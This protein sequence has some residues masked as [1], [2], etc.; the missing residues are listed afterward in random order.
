MEGF[1]RGLNRL[2]KLMGSKPDVHVN[3]QQAQRQQIRLSSS[4]S[5]VK[6]KLAV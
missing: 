5:N 3:V 4:L 1:I 2:V 6:V